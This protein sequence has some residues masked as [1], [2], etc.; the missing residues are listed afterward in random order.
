LIFCDETNKNICTNIYMMRLPARTWP[1]TY[2]STYPHI[3]TAS[4]HATHPRKPKH[5]YL[6]TYTRHYN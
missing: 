6:R 4:A 5:A 2:A 1:D 3:R